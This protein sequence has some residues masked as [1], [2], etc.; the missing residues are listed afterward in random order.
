MAKFT[1]MNPGD[2]II[3]RGRAALLERQPFIEAIRSAQ[4]GRIE[5]ERGDQPNRVRRLLRLAA[6][7]A[8]V[9]VRSS[10]E[11]SSQKALL[12]KRTKK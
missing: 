11:D 8:G 10:W 2:V 6:R 3:G 5:L 1:K 12:W 7:D 4:A 9:G